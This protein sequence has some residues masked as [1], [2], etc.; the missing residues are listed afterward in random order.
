MAEREREVLLH[1]YDLNESNGWLLAVGFGA[2][3]TVRMLKY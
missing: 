1:V 3:H 2:F